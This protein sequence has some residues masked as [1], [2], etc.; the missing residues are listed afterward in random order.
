MTKHTF[1]SIKQKLTRKDFIYLAVIAVALVSLIGVLIWQQ[2]TQHYSVIQSSDLQSPHDADEEQYDWKVETWLK[3]LRVVSDMAWDGDTLWL[4]ERDGKVKRVDAQKR[5]TEIPGLSTKVAAVGESGLTGLAL[6]PDFAR[7]NYIYLYYTYRDGGQMLNRV[8][9]FTLKNDRLTDETYVVD[10]LP[11]GSIHNGGRMRFGPDQQLWV[12]TGDAGRPQFPQSMDSL[13]GKVLRMD[14]TGKPLPDN[15]FPNSLIYSIGHRNPQG[16]AWH[17][18]TEELVVNSH[19]E[20]AHDEIDI[21]RL[22]SNHGWADVKQCFS[23]DKRFTNPIFCS[24]NVTW[25]PSGAVFIGTD[26]WRFRYSYVFA[27]LRGNLL[28]RIAIMDGNVVEDENIIDGGYGRLRSVSV[29][30][31]K[32][33]YVGTSNYDGRGE[34]QPGDDKILRVTPVLKSQ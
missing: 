18:L 27:G 34:P 5:V 25:A 26:P 32:S 13:G 8:S 3:D 33:L 20:S 14:D 2:N 11:G 7:N 9:R 28:K 31:D 24:G 22:G 1:S 6:H 19:G 12:L 10:A 21:V 4:T 23:D 29:G 17:P 16:L 30:P 15:P